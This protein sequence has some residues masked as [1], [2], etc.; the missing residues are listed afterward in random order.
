MTER[1]L[2]AKESIL[3]GCLVTPHVYEGVLERFVKF[4]APFIEHLNVRTQRQKAIDYMKGLISDTERKNVESIAYYHGSDRQPLQKFIGQ[5]EWDDEIILDELARRI[6]REIGTKNGVIILDPTS[7]PKKGKQS[8][9]VQRQWCGRLGKLENCQ[10]A[11]FLAYA[12]ADEFALVDRR[13]YLP[14]EWIDDPN[15]CRY[16]G[17]PEEHIVEKTRHVQAIEMLKGRG[18]ILPHD[19]VAGDDEMGSE[20]DGRSPSAKVIRFTLFRSL[21]PAPNGSGL[22]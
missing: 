3:E 5:V 6:K 11:I 8:V 13:L 22:L 12:G 21:A 19:W 17:V 20:A 16:A 9:G 2:I 7:F 18:K 1:Y 14:K 10:V 4:V 15:R